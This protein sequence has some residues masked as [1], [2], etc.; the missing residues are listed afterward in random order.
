MK[1]K[2]GGYMG[3]DRHIERWR[4]LIA[5]NERVIEML[6]SGKMR[7]Y[8]GSPSNSESDISG[9]EAERLREIGD[10]LNQLVARLEQTD[11]L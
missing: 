10:L 2:P 5:G 6:E 1:M 4:E 7:Q 9:R 3:T 8:Y 11:V